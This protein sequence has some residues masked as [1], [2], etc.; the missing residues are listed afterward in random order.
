MVRYLMYKN[1][2]QNMDDKRLGGWLEDTNSGLN[3]W[4]IE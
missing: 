3:H 4:E 2:L 1:K